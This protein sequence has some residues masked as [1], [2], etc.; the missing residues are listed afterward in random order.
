M[1]SNWSYSSFL[2]WLN[3][4]IVAWD[5]AGGGYK[6]MEIFF[7]ACQEDKYIFI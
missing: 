5:M 1:C 7:Q 2:S 3:L 4:G 6:F